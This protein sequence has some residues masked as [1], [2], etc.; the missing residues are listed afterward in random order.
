MFGFIIT[1]LFWAI[2]LTLVLLYVSPQS[3]AN[4]QTKVRGK[5]KK[6]VERYDGP[7]N[8]PLGTTPS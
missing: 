4:L 3:I 8:P 7:G 5:A 6:I 2:I 1:T